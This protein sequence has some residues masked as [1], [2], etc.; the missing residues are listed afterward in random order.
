MGRFGGDEFL[1]VLP[2]TAPSEAVHFAERLRKQITELDIPLDRARDAVIFTI[3]V[4][5]AGVPEHG[6]CVDK[7]LGIADRAMYEGKRRSGNCVVCPDGNTDF[8]EGCG[9]LM[10]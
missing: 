6:E 1:V 10:L 7:L 9:G 8:K 2:E 4:G 3:S 5:L